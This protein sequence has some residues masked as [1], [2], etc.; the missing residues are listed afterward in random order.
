MFGGG[1]KIRASEKELQQHGQGDSQRQQYAS[2]LEVWLCYT[3]ACRPCVTGRMAPVVSESWSSSPFYMA[4]GPRAS[5]LCPAVSMSFCSVLC[6]GRSLSTV[7]LHSGTLQSTSDTCTCP[8]SP[9]AQQAAQRE[10]IRRKGQSDVPPPSWIIPLWGLQRTSKSF[11]LRSKHKKTGSL[12]SVM[13]CCPHTSY[14]GTSSSSSSS[15]SVVYGF[16]SLRMS[17]M[18]SATGPISSISSSSVSVAQAELGTSPSSCECEGWG[19]CELGGRGLSV[20]VAGAGDAPTV[21]L[22]SRLHAWAP[23]PTLALV[24]VR[25][26]SRKLARG[27]RRRTPE[28][29]EPSIAFCSWKKRKMSEKKPHE[30]EAGPALP[31]RSS[32]VPQGKG[33]T[34]RVTALPL[35]PVEIIFYT[36]DV[37]K[38]S[39]VNNK[40]HTSFRNSNSHSVKSGY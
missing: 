6:L 33:I 18:F 8:N 26:M 1:C 22:S 31:S 36:G 11:S 14:K 2:R 10:S 16:I 27:G 9:A 4:D 30:R 24:E 28:R 35:G 34:N 5:W 40:F 21:P 3:A 38:N 12:K 7:S 29:V 20:P 17:E 13:G 32:S 23:C 39:V 37:M 15:R 19:E 25:L